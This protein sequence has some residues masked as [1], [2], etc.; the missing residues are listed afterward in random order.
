MIKGLVMEKLIKFVLY[1]DVCL[2]IYCN[3]NCRNGGFI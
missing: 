1:L 2:V 3:I